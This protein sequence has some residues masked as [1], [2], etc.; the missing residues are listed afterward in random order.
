VRID[1]DRII[2][3]LFLAKIAYKAH[4]TAIV[5]ILPTNHP[6]ERDSKRGLSPMDRKLRSRGFRHTWGP[7]PGGASGKGLPLQRSWAGFGGP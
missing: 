1:F 2:S 6:N 5:R 3:L 7:P 4:S